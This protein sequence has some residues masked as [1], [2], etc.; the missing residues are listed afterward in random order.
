[1]ALSYTLVL[2][3]AG[4]VYAQER[5]MFADL[6]ASALPGIARF[7]DGSISD[8]DALVMVNLWTQKAISQAAA[9]G[10]PVRYAYYL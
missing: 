4:H 8:R 3:N 6:P 1:M 5:R 7:P 9:A 10:L 2:L